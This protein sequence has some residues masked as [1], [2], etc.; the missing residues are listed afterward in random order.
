MAAN[1]HGSAPN[2]TVVEL[3]QEIRE[4]GTWPEDRAVKRLLHSL[5]LTGGARHRAVTV[6]M[7]LDHLNLSIA[8]RLALA[9]EGDWHDLGGA[10]AGESADFVSLQMSQGA[11]N[12]A[13][14]EKHHSRE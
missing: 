13:E 7:A 14:K 6:A 11:S 1:M 9:M 5:E 3:R 12:V 10:I 8:R 4:H 2:D